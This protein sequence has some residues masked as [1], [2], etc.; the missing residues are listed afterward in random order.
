MDMLVLRSE[1][2]SHTRAV[3][4]RKPYVLP[5]GDPR[6]PAHVS[7]RSWHCYLVGGEG[8]GESAGLPMERTKK[9]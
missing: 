9:N 2:W 8:Q 6:C 7:D 1:S 5:W 4:I 3:S